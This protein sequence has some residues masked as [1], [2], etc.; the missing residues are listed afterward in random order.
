[1][2]FD[3]IVH[4]VFTGGAEPVD[5]F[6]LEFLQNLHNLLSDDGAIAINY[7]GN[8]V[9][10]TPKII[11][12]TIQAVFPICRIF[13]ESPRD[14]D[15]FARTGSDFTNLIF[16]C[17][18]TPADADAGADPEKALPFREPTDQDCL[19]SRARYAYLKPRFEVTPEEFLGELPPSKDGGAAR[20]DKAADEYGILKKGETGRVQEWHRK[21]AAGHWMI[22]RSVFKSS[23]WENW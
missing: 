7:A 8:L 23:F 14:P 2:T 5:L 21:S 1:M 16:F 22:M 12:Q 10:P 13:R 3:Y 11:L 15:F 4:D 18:K 9:L 19:K 6:T 17:R 20:A